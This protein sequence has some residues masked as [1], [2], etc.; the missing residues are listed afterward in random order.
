MPH[1]LEGVQLLDLRAHF[2]A[3]LL[4][5]GDRHAVLEYAT[6]HAAYGY[7]AYVGV[8]VQRCDEHL[9][10]ALQHLRLGYVLDDGV[11]QG[12]DIVGRLLPVGTHPAVLG[13]AVDGLEVQLL[14]TGVEVAHQVEHGLLHLIRTAVELVHLVDHHDR[15]EVKLDGFL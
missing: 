4:G 5:Q 6:V 11:H 13:R 7:T 10:R 2:R 9:R 1:A 14:L 12:G 3:V 15:L 8:V